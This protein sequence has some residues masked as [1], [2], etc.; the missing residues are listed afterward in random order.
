MY[1]ENLNLK[2]I[3]R[4][5]VKQLPELR[6]ISINLTGCKAEVEVKEKYKVPTKVLKIISH[7]T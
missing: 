4:K 3:E 7:Q 1:K 2:D 6:W 5:V